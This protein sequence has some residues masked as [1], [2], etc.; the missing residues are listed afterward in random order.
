MT[1]LTN[2]SNIVDEFWQNVNIDQLYKIYEV[3]R[4]VYIVAP[5]TLEFLAMDAYLERQCIGHIR[6]SIISDR[7]QK[8]NFL[9]QGIEVSLESN[10]I[11]SYYF[12][13]IIINKKVLITVK[14]HDNP[15]TL[16]DKSDYRELFAKSNP[17]SMPL[18]DRL[19]F[20]IDQEDKDKSNYINCIVTHKLPEHITLIFPCKRYL[21]LL[22]EPI[23][24][25][26]RCQEYEQSDNFRKQSGDLKRTDIEKNSIEK[27]PL[28]LR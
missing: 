8:M 25:L 7:L 28:K 15:M 2:G 18:L 11:G 21:N 13:K 3:I 4:D 5:S 10:I 26:S 17:D 1:N 14:S 24:L 16:P 20:R 23:D 27:K 22:S 9:S 12:A 19:N 6:T